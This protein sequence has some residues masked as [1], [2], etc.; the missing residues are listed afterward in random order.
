MRIYLTFDCEDFINPSSIEALRYVLELLGKYDFTGIFFLTGQFCEILKDN[1]E[2]LNLL[3]L[4]EIGYHSTSH[5]VHPGIFEYTDIKNYDEAYELAL[6]QETSRINPLS[7]KIDGKGGLLTL[8]RVFPQKKI[9]S[10]RAPGFCWSPPHLDALKKL[11]IRFDF[12]TNLSP[13]PVYYKRIT[14]YPFPILGF[15]MLTS[16]F[17]PL[18]NMKLTS[19]VRLI[20]KSVVWHPL[21]FF[22]HP[23]DFTN[24]EL[25]DQ[26]YFVN[27]P[28]GLHTVRTRNWHET[29]KLLKC[30]ELFL[31][32]VH[33]LADKGVL[34]VT[35]AL[36]EGLLKIH[37][38]NKQIIHS[39]RRSVQWCTRFF[40]YTPKFVLNHFYQYFNTDVRSTETNSKLNADCFF[41]R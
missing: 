24:G 37:F 30:F 40:N 33:S 11:G 13:I 17:L 8:H 1:P 7:G 36:E 28:T 3:E 29:A 14:F 38:T 5:S 10:F 22:L 27:N 12:S 9:V 41:R 23:H 19:M 31:R 15:E 20:Q 34:E 6:R 25:W 32:R 35:P 39:Y 26:D 4:H 21:V 16:N 2:V 18:G